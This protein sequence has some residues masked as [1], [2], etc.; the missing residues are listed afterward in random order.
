VES[1]RDTRIVGHGVHGRRAI[2]D[3]G[4]LI[5]GLG[6]KRMWSWRRSRVLLMNVRKGQDSEAGGNMT[7]VG[8]VLSHGGDLG[9]WKLGPVS[10]EPEAGCEGFDVFK[11]LEGL[12][13]VQIES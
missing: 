11:G 2:V 12:S 10:D 9:T 4:A 3:A 7:R 6:S 5:S 13:S 8:V 1:Q